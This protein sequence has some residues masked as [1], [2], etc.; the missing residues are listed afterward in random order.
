MPCYTIL[1]YT[2]ITEQVKYAEDGRVEMVSNISQWPGPHAPDHDVEE[3]VVK[4]VIVTPVEF[5]GPIVELVKAKR[6]ED[7]VM[8]Y[9]DD[10]SVKMESIIPWQEV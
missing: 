2:N 6:G 1:H 3:P 7:I 8:V 10:G 5:Y 9:L 4:I